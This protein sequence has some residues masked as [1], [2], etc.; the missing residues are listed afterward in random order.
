VYSPLFIRVYANKH[1]LS[2]TH[3]GVKKRTKQRLEKRIFA[4]KMANM[5]PPAAPPAKVAW[6]EDLNLQLICRDCKEVPPNLVEEFASGDTVCGSCGLVL[7]ERIVDTRSEWRTFSNDDQGSDDPSRVGD[8]PNELMIGEQLH[9]TIAFDGGGGNA[10]SRDL[11][12]AQSKAVHDRASKGLM[13]AY[14]EIGALCDSLS[15]SGDTSHTAKNLFKQVSEGNAF[16]TKSQETVIA[17]C[18]FIACRQ[19]NVPRSFREIFALTR[20]SKAEIGRTF[21]ALEK[22]FAAENAKKRAKAE[23]T[24]GK[25]TLVRI[26]FCSVLLM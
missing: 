14:K 3:K 9:T 7:G 16:R 4:A 17:G 15:I 12:R 5:G 2:T 25:F 26:I 8:A 19:T 1:N 13:A 6:K 24:G 21:K 22:F 10:K 23:E 11:H 20:V 18:I